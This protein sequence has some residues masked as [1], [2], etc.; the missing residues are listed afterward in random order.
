MDKDI[1]LHAMSPI[2]DRLL[3]WIDLK[4]EKDMKICD[5]QYEIQKNI[6]TWYDIFEVHLEEFV[7]NTDSIE[8]YIVGTTGDFDPLLSTKLS[9]RM[10]DSDYYAEVSYQDRQEIL[11]QILNTDKEDLLEAIKLFEKMNEED[12]ICVVGNKDALEKC[13]DKFKE[14]FDFNAK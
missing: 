14:I 7:K 2:F 9:I 4:I 12:N 13:K 5:L 11:D 3:K 10:A 8:N 1:C 6:S